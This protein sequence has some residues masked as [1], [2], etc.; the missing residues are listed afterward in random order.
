MSYRAVRD[1]FIV[2]SYVHYLLQAFLLLYSAVL[3][4][5]CNVTSQDAVDDSRVESFLDVDGDLEPLY[6]P[7]IIEELSAF[8]NEEV[9]VCAQSWALR[10]VDTKVC[11]ATD[12]L[13][14]GSIDLKWT[15]EVVIGNVVINTCYLQ[16]ID[17]AFGVTESLE[18]VSCLVSV[19]HFYVF[20]ML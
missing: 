3:T 10:H 11:K 8:I 17:L 14:K 13:H 5:H 18:N 1:A 16:V 6:S 19:I 20:V 2:L 12:F 4:P 15:V 9:S 7:Q